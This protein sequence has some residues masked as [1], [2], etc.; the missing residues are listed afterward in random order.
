MSPVSGISRVSRDCQNTCRTRGSGRDTGT[1]SI[2]TCPCLS[3]LPLPCRG[4][5][6]GTC[7]ALVPVCPAL[8]HADRWHCAKGTPPKTARPESRRV[9]EAAAPWTRPRSTIGF[10]VILS[11]RALG[12]KAAGPNLARRVH[13]PQ[14]DGFLT[15]SGSDVR[16]DPDKTVSLG[17]RP[18]A[19]FDHGSKGRRFLKVCPIPLHS[20]CP[21][22]SRSSKSST[23]SSA[24]LTR[25]TSDSVASISFFRTRS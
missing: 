19:A 2:D 18:E 12:M 20:V 22:S 6:S 10:M 1:G 16:H 25:D 21:P 9:I 15:V 24:P 5:T 8:D 14:N 17:V 7:P 13:P 3:R 11:A 23:R 4:E